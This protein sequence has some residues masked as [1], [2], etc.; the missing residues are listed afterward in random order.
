MASM[1]SADEVF[2]IGVEIEKNGRRFYEEAARRVDDP[3]ARRLLGELAEWEAQHVATF[4]RLRE[5]FAGTGEEAGLEDANDE[6]YGY[7]KAAA[8]SHVFVSTRDVGAVVSGCRTVGD[9]LRLALSFEKDSVVVYTAMRMVV[10]ER[11]GRDRI[12]RLVEEELKHVTMLK[13]LHER[14]GGADGG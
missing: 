4:E 14:H 11:L 13:R 7:L 8:D 5:E 2:R 10:P 6:V 3:E 9:F 12:D 1:Y